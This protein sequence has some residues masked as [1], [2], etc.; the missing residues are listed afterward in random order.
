M[1][2]G[3]RRLSSPGRVPGVLGSAGG[4]DGPALT[5][6]TPGCPVH[7]RPLP[8][9]SGGSGSPSPCTSQAVPARDWDVCASGGPLLR[10]PHACGILVPRPEVRPE[11][12]WWELWV[13]TAGLT[14]NLR[15]QGISVAVRLPRGPHLSTKTPLYPTDCKLQCWMSQA[16]QLVRQEYSATQQKKNQ[17]LKWQ[18]ICYR[19]R[20]KVKTYKTK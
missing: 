12:L 19:K 20:S 3:C 4:A 2:P 8:C 17:K 5:L 13:Q 16:K 14:E 11:I 15:P 1:N 10:L 9:P 18:N 6:R 7:L